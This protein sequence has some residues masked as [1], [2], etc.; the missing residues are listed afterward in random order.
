[1][2]FEAKASWAVGSAGLSWWGRAAA[3]SVS[4]VVN[5]QDATGA[6]DSTESGSDWG[7]A[8]VGD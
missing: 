7:S 3:I 4:T 2:G 6:T 8:K 5:R 1:M